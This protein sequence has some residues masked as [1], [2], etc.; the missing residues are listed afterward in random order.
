[1]CNCSNRMKVN[2]QLMLAVCASF[3][4]INPTEYYPCDSYARHMKP[5]PEH[6]LQCTD[7]EIFDSEYDSGLWERFRI[8]PEDEEERER[9]E[10]E[11]EEN[12]TW[13]AWDELRN[14]RVSGCVEFKRGIAY[15]EHIGAI[16]EDCETMGTIGGPL[17]FGVV[18]DMSFRIESKLVVGTVRV[19]PFIFRGIVDNTL[20]CSL[21]SEATWERIKGLFREHDLWELCR[22]AKD[23][24]V[25]A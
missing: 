7:D 3:E 24:E 12:G 23:K 22:M 2:T 8:A 15:L 6:K 5:L 11:A 1:M 21:V 9:L 20:S 4:G 17:S 25:Y 19:T 13:K 10:S 14:I 16:F 18:P